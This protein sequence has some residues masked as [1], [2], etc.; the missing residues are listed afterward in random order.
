MTTLRAELTESTFKFNLGSSVL[1]VSREI[2]I[3]DSGCLD[4]TEV[5]KSLKAIN[6]ILR[7]H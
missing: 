3:F 4:F 7:T 6:T 5:I 2:T 1:F